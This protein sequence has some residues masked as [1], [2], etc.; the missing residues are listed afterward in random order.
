MVN[1]KK[2]RLEID[3][4]YLITIALVLGLH[5]SLLFFKNID[6]TSLAQKLAQFS[7]T[8]SQ[9]NSMKVKY[10]RT[11]GVKNG[12]K[13]NSTYL[14]KDSG[15]TKS[16]AQD[17]F[18]IAKTFKPSPKDFT[19]PRKAKD[20]FKE[21]NANLKQTTKQDLNKISQTEKAI[22]K[23]FLPS[24]AVQ[25][26]GQTKHHSL[27]NSDVL[28]NLEV[29]EGVNLD[30]LNEKELK[31]YGFQRRMA[32]NYVNS[33][34]T[35]LSDFTRKNPHLNFPMTNEKQ[36]LT[37]RVTF[38]SAGNIMQIKMIR[39]TN[40]ETLQNFFVEVLE[41]IRSL[42]NPPEILWSKTGEFNVFYSL[43]ING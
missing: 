5:A 42:P 27:S 32:N 12:N 41:E 9:D 30:E 1:H 26:S 38:D 13:D 28:V 35:K 21:L 18:S 34:Y 29:P 25:L 3:P 31:F 37:G 33:F 7:K 24:D 22:P 40:I 2:I 16:I 39:W 20:L 43:V 14:R 15:K 4:I 19:P 6:T 23:A 36:V 10:L 17:P 8:Q 11:V